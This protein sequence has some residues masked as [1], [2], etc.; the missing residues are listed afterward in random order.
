[1]YNLYLKILNAGKL[2]VTPNKVYA[3]SNRI[4]LTKD[5]VYTHPAEKVCNYSYSHPTT[6]QCNASTEISS[7]KSSVSEGKSLI[8]AAVTGKGVQTAADATFQTMANNIWGIPSINSVQQL[9]LNNSSASTSYS[10]MGGTLS[11]LANPVVYDSRGRSG[12][13]NVTAATKVNFIQLYFNY[14][15]YS[16]YA[17]IRLLFDFNISTN[18]IVFRSPSVN[19]SLVITEIYGHSVV[20]SG[21]SY[22]I[23][24]DVNI[25]SW[26]TTSSA[27]TIAGRQTIQVQWSNPSC[28]Y[29]I[30]SSDFNYNWVL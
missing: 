20:Q 24:F 10:Y 21:S 28:W 12:A 16:T 1:M 30:G 19:N 8:A 11:M 26:Y 25:P 3:G 7:L 14:L 13:F 22:I 23:S 6:I 9:I 27:T 29:N 17:E 4:D 2:L 5:T 18:G 15:S